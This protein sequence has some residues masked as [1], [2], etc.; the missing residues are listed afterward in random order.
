MTTLSDKFLNHSMIFQLETILCQ[1]R[2]ASMLVQLPTV[3]TTES[4]SERKLY[5]L[6]CVIS[7]FLAL[8]VKRMFSKLVSL[9][10]HFLNTN[11]SLFQQL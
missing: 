9:D 3:T 8:D 2:K 6:V 4:A 5:L 10:I 1:S 11:E 7:D